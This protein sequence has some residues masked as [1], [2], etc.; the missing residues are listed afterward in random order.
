M[1]Y[2]HRPNPGNFRNNSS[3]FRGVTLNRRRGKY[4]SQIGTRGTMKFLG[5]FDSALEAAAR[6]DQVAVELHGEYAVTNA[7]LG[8]L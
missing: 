8:L 6:Y 3:E 1:N 7:S 2:R 5:N 4:Q